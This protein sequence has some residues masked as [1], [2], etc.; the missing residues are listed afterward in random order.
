MLFL[1]R[2]PSHRIAASAL[3]REVFIFPIGAPIKGF[4]FTMSAYPAI[5]SR[6]SPKAARRFLAAAIKKGALRIAGLPGELLC[7]QLS[8]LR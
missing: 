6:S 5:M 2:N 7:W 3:L 8:P 1:S 4:V